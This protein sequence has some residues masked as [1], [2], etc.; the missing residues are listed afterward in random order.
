MFKLFTKSKEEEEP[1][2]Y[3]ANVFTDYTPIPDQIT[4]ISP[5]WEEVF[6]RMDAIEAKIDLLLDNQTF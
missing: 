1:M 6:E 5:L 2:E 4:E 3:E